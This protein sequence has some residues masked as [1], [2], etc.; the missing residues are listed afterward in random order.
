MNRRKTIFTAVAATA[1]AVAGIG[2]AMAGVTPQ[3]STPTTSSTTPAFGL[4]P[5]EFVGAAGDCGPG[6]PAGTDT[7]TA[8]WDSTTGNPAPSILL[9]KTGLI[10]NC[11]AAGVDIID[12]A[13]ENGPASGIDE[14]NFDFKGYC[15][16]GAPRFNIASG[17][18]TAF[19]GCAGGT[20]GTAGAAGSGYTHVEFTQAQIDAALL[21][22]GIAPGDN[23]DDL[24]IIF[25]EIGSTNID[26]ISVNGDVVGSPT[27]PITAEDCKN[28]GYKN[29]NF[30]VSFK[31][32]G[33][34]VSYVATKG[35]NPPSGPKNVQQ[36]G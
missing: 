28:G 10:T 32:Q 8:R 23:V 11:A 30:Y 33:D 6:Y 29:P 12:P 14:L 26:N 31:N 13:V 1:F 21:A 22:A 18:K 34:C 25:D 9:E 27:F 16:A 15:G 5:F 19:L 36:H 4:Q 35:K 20:V 7:V 17:N 3:A 24:Y 2:G